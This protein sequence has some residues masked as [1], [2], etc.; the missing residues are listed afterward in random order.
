MRDKFKLKGTVRLKVYENGVLIDEHVGSNL[1]VDSGYEMLFQ[2]IVTNTP[3]TIDMVGVGSDGTAPAPDNRDLTTPFMRMI[4]SITLITPT[5]FK[6]DFTIGSGDANGITI[7]EFGLFMFGM[8]FA[9][10]TGITIAKNPTISIS[11]E[12]TIEI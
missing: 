7:R 1:V 10:K 4:T 11:G 3:V 9:R 5:S 12:W 8:L 2:R 6:C